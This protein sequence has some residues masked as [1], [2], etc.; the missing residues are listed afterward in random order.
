MMLSLGEHSITP[1]FGELLG[2]EVSV[3]EEEN[4]HM[5]TYYLIEVAF[6]GSLSTCAE[7]DSLEQRTEQS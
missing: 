3:H 1:R 4:V 5:Q 2:H 6:R 7:R